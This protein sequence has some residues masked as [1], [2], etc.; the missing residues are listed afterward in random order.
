MQGYKNLATLH[1]TQR[2]LITVNCRTYYILNFPSLN[3]DLNS[4][5]SGIDTC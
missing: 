3:V 2:L 1:L 4:K 5:K